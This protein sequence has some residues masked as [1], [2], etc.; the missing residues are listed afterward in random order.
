[1]KEKVVSIHG[2]VEPFKDK[3]KRLKTEFSFRSL[4]MILFGIAL[5]VANIVLFI[6]AIKRAGETRSIFEIFM[7]F[8]FGVIGVIASSILIFCVTIELSLP[9]DNI[10]I[11][12]YSK[13]KYLNEEQEESQKKQKK[14]KLILTIFVAIAMFAVGIGTS[15]IYIRDEIKYS[16]YPTVEATIVDFVGTGDG[17]K[18]VYEYRVDG[19][20]YRYTSHIE[21][22]G[23][24]VPY[25]GDK[26]IL[27]YNPNNPSEVYMKNE[28]MFFLLFGSTFILF[29]LFIVCSILQEKKIISLKFL[30]TLILFGISFICFLAA[31]QTKAYGDFIAIFSDNLWLFFTMMF[32]YVGLMEFFSMLVWIGKKPKETDSSEV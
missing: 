4:L 27:K 14:K 5:F 9:P 25:I 8:L 23:E 30:V 13:K 24:A 1:M 6:F 11:V 18:T 28:S 19:K 22:S 26:E 12:S 21:S 16:N 20:K 3:F 10:K 7:S 32:T 31:Y 29:G 2:K 17:S 15:S